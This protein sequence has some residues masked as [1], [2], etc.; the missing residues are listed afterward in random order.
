VSTVPHDRRTVFC[1][2]YPWTMGTAHR[3]TTAT[4]VPTADSDSSGCNA[5]WFHTY[6]SRPSCNKDARRGPMFC[7]TV[8]VTSYVKLK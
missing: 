1:C 7:C 5:K 8:R 3:V 4:P 6:M 2:K